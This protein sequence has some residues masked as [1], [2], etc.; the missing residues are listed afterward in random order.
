MQHVGAADHVFTIEQIPPAPGSANSS[1]TYRIYQS[2]NGAYSL[3]AWLADDM[4]DIQTDRGDII[5]PHLTRCVK[6]TPN[7]QSPKCVKLRGMYEGLKSQ[8]VPLG[9]P[10]KDFLDYNEN[11]DLIVK[12]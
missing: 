5:I 8:F 11:F 2:Y 10:Y 3:R 1:P 4:K 9:G 7:D 12:F 6:E